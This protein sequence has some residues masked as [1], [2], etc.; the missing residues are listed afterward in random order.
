MK[1]KIILSIVSILITV[2]VLLL[3]LQQKKSETVSKEDKDIYGL[4][5]VKLNDH[6]MTTD[7]FIINYLKGYLTSED[8]TIFSTLSSGK[9]QLQ[10]IQLDVIHTGFSYSEHP[11]EETEGFVNEEGTLTYQYD[12]NTPF[13]YSFSAEKEGFALI[14]VYF[15]VKG[16]L[17]GEPVTYKA[18][19]KANNQELELSEQYTEQPIYDNKTKM[20]HWMAVFKLPV[21]QYPPEKMELE[22]KMTID[23]KIFQ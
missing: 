16:D 12:Q 23:G 5:E 3:F 18:V 2:S 14:P 19:L 15:A 17:Q 22:V 1:K 4:I 7:E 8:G 11:E 10:M 20:T 21:D 9:D 13:K 6:S